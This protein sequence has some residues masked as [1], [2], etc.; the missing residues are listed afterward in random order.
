MNL[1]KTDNTGKIIAAAVIGAIGGAVLGLLF[2]PAK[3]SETRQKLASG[4]GKVTDELK[5][6][7]T[8]KAEMVKNKAQNGLQQMKDKGRAAVSAVEHKYEEYKQ[9]M[10]PKTGGYTGGHVHGNK[11]DL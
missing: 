5:E 11:H 2:A 3:G 9:S 4:L 7:A 1:F 6:S 8:E 10:Q